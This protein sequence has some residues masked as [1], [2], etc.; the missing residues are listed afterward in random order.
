MLTFP[1]L[2]T[3]SLYKFYFI[4]GFIMMFLSIFVIY[5]RTNKVFVAATQIDSLDSYFTKSQ[6]LEIELIE[7]Q[8]KVLEETS[9]SYDKIIKSSPSVT[10]LDSS[11]IIIKLMEER[12]QI[13]KQRYIEDSISQ[14][15]FLDYKIQH[16]KLNIYIKDKTVVVVSI[17]FFLLGG[18]FFGYGGYYWT[19]KLQEPQDKILEIQLK[20]LEKELDTVNRY[21]PKR[22]IEPKVFSKLQ[23][24]RNFQ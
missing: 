24:Q 21:F 6:E 13:Q 17:L 2:P 20:L 18:Y 19:K 12:L 23:R 7:N 1:N 22:G 16:D 4:V 5:D 3:D 10:P 9:Q 15:K 8:N 11:R 14:R